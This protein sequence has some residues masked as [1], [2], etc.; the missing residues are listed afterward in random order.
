MVGLH[1]KTIQRNPNCPLRSLFFS[2][3]IT[4]KGTIFKELHQKGNAF[5]YI[6]D[7]VNNDAIRKVLF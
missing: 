1:N 6:G 4:E 3:L 5:M 7:H 2:P